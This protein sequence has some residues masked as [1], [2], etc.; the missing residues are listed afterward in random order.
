MLD[1]TQYSSWASRMLL[2]IKGKGNGKL[3]VD[4][5]L[6]GPFDYGTVTEAGTA[7]HLK[8]LD[9][10]D[11]DCDEAPSASA[12]LMAKLSSYDSEVLSE[13]PIHDNYLDNHVTDQNVMEKRFLDEYSECVEL[14]AEL[15]KKNEM[16]EKA[17]YD[18]LSKRVLE[19]KQM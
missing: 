5:V 16:V 13:F 14:K 11:S 4:S 6:N 1:K 9:A 15:S 18:E 2:Y 12:V 10:I 3:L 7:L 8:L 19:W 17:I